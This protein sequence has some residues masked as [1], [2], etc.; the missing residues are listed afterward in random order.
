MGHIFLINIIRSATKEHIKPLNITRTNLKGE[1]SFSAYMGIVSMQGER[2]TITF[3]DIDL[4]EPFISYNDAMWSYFEPELN[5]RLSE[6]DVD[7]STSARVRSALT[8][9]LPGGMFG[10]DDVAEKLGFSK[11]TLQRKLSE[12]NTTFQKQ[13]NST[14]EVL[15]I[16]YIKNTD[17]IMN[18]IAY[19]LGYAELNSFFR[20]F[21]LWTGRNVSEYRNESQ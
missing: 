8:E 2:N 10:I 9:L 15:A 11:R 19:L 20:A 7:D 3:R 1:N 12:E 14:R 16:H 18:D 4:L 6:L 21:T 5:K 13:L 17:M